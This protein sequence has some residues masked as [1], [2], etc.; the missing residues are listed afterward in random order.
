MKTEVALIWGLRVGGKRPY[1]GHHVH[2]VRGGMTTHCTER[3][4][5]PVRVA[6]LPI[7]EYR[8]LLRI[9]K[10]SANKDLSGGG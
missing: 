1:I 3:Y 8:R 7:A 6:V 4:H 9:E 10:K 2:S 5:R